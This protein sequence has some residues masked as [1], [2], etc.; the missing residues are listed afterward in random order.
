MYRDLEAIKVHIFFNKSMI[1]KI[2]T[3]KLLV[4]HNIQYFTLQSI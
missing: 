4:S 2:C 3:C 1:I